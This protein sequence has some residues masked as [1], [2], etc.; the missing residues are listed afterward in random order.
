MSKELGSNAAV[1]GPSDA[2]T[3]A[4]TNLGRALAAIHRVL[5]R[6]EESG[7]AAEVQS[8]LK[9]AA[10]CIELARQSHQRI[11]T[12]GNPGMAASVHTGL[13]PELVAVI[14]AAVAAVLDRPYRLVSV[15]PLAAAVPHLN[16]WALEGRTQI[17]QSHKIR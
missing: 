3:E 17:F 8:A 9:K 11:M 16:V 13:E 4:E 10:D 15:Q 7:R 1:A 14:S 5:P 6:L 2:L 12:Q